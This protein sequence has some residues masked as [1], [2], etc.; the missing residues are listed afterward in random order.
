[1]SS[2]KQIE[3]RRRRTQELLQKGYNRKEISEKLKVH[4]MTTVGDVKF[5]N[6]RYKKMVQD[7]PDYLNKQLEKIFQFVEELNTLKKEYWKIKESAG[8]FIEITDKKGNKKKIPLG[9]LE[10]QRKTLDSIRQVI[11]EQAKILKLVGNTPTYLQQNY[12]HIDDVNSKIK[13]LIKHFIFIIDKHIPKEK[14]EEALRDLQ[15]YK[16]EVIDVERSG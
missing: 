14:Q 16:G 4:Y 8:E 9:S 7:N 13:K 2:E 1:M 5:L 11:M 10:D 12:F 15:S 6:E 3:E